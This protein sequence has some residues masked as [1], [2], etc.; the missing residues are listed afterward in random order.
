M[1]LRTR[2]L[3]FFQGALGVVLL[4]FSVSLYLLVAGHLHHQ[5][6]ERLDSAL[7]TLAAAAEVNAEGVE[8]EPE[9]R[10]LRFGRR[11]VESG[12]VWRVADDDG[13]RVDGSDLEAERALAL[14]QGVAAPTRTPLTLDDRAG[15]RWRVLYRRLAA[16]D[17]REAGPRSEEGDAPAS[18]AI[19]A[20]LWLAA[21]VS[22]D[23]AYETLNRLA[24]ALA[25]LSLGLWLA[26]MTLGGRLCRRALKPVSAMADA[27]HA[28]GGEPSSRR[29]PPP[30]TGD[31]LDDLGRSFNA[32]L[33]RL[34]ESFERQRRFT[35]DASHQLR[36]PLTTMLGNLD[37]ALKQRRTPEEYERVLAL[38]RRKARQMRGMIESLLFLARA[39]AESL[40]PEL[41]PMD[42]ASWL[43]EFLG[44]RRDAPRGPDLRLEIDHGGP[45]VVR[46]HPSLLGDLLDNLL[47]NAAKYSEPGTPIVVRLG[48]DAASTSLS[49]VD[50][51]IGVEEGDLPHL[52]EPFYRSPAAL[53]R[54]TTGVGL[55]LSIVRRLAQALGAA[56]EVRS[57]AG[58]GSSFTVRFTSVDRPSHV[59][60]SRRTIEEAG[61]AR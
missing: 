28:I 4:G 13:R 16:S 45:A 42:L 1:T 27:A 54:A 9:E 39:D 8:W 55:G 36:T 57:R 6:D 33:D 51:G 59:V 25:G 46:A 43:V 60:E 41:G 37:L 52:F 19:R 50:G 38:T 31:E 58:E 47:D 40:H 20:E 61:R 24:L 44:P 26:M 10:D 32:L 3:L 49:V 11:A 18:A 2:L 53:G 23:G 35:G 56:V 17:R 22:L 14:P 15:G 30:A 34:Q 5:A 12:L 7:N 48:R 29:L 21:G